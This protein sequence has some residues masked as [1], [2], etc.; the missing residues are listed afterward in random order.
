MRRSANWLDTISTGM[1]YVEQYSP[2][3][4]PNGDSATLRLSYYFPIMQFHSRLMTDNFVLRDFVTG[5]T[6]MK[7]VY[8]AVQHYKTNRVNIVPHEQYPEVTSQQQELLDAVIECAEENDLQLLFLNVA[9]DLSEEYESSINAAV[10]YVQEK[11]YPVLDCND[12]EVLAASGLD[13]ETDFFDENHMNALGA[14]KFTKF[15]ASWVKEQVELT[16][17]RG[18]TRYES[19]DD[20]AEYY[21]EWYEESLVDI[22]KWI[23]KYGTDNLNKTDEE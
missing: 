2:E 15:L 18:D 13:G 6:K 7:G 23:K 20:A 17:H 3:T 11:G 19:W 14:N 4:I 1:D 9:T 16:D 10:R 12:A 22:A 21:D 8:T 5:T